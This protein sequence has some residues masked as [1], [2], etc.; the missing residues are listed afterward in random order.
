MIIHVSHRLN[1]T[2][3]TDNGIELLSQHLELENGL[4]YLSIARN[5][6]ITNKS[7]PFLILL[8]EKLRIKKLNIGKT[9]IISGNKLIAPVIRNVLQY[10]NNI[11]ISLASK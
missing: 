6:H 5:K 9:S 1:N 3:L 4:E 7:I 10:G 8:I 2:K 11:K